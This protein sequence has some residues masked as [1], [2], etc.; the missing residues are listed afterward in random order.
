MLVRT[1]FSPRLTILVPRIGFYAYALLG[2][3]STV[4]F[5]KRYL[6]RGVKFV[7]VGA[8][9]GTY[10]ILAAKLGCEAL[11]FDPSDIC[12]ILTLVNC[13]LN[14]VSV[15]AERVA[16]GEYSSAKHVRL[17]DLEVTPDVIKIDVDGDELLV[18]ESGKK[19]LR[20]AR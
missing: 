20:N 12:H 7:D 17:D 13:R 16:V 19:V 18:I 1:P 9:V 5:V 3:I 2:E 6:G 11:A 8:G 10:S 4:E 15:R 14:G